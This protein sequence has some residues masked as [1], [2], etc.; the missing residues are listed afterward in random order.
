MSWKGR[1]KPMASKP[2]AK[3]V[4]KLYIEEV[5]LPDESVGH[6]K[7]VKN[8]KAWAVLLADGYCVDCWDKGV[9]VRAGRRNSSADNKAR[10]EELQRQRNRKG[11]YQSD[12]PIKF[13]NF[14]KAG[15]GN[16]YQQ[17]G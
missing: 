4:A 14:T 11:Q 12:P 10:Y 8:C 3:G 15:K 17:M 6:C 7:N 16:N 1:G 9:N 2:T 5:Y 13:K